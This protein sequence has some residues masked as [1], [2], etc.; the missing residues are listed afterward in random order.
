MK[1]LTKKALQEVVAKLRRFEDEIQ[2]AYVW[3]DDKFDKNE[4]NHNV[5]KLTI[6]AS[7]LGD[8]VSK[9]IDNE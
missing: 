4:H 6:T 7:N 8:W 5:S 2:T 3:D 9:C 1:D